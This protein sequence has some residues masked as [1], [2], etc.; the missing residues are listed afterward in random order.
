MIPKT[1][2]RHTRVA[3][4]ACALLANAISASAQTNTLVN[5]GTNGLL[6]YTPIGSGNVVPDYSGVGYKNGE[7]AIPSVPV[8]L[9]LDAVAGDNRAAIQAAINQVAAMPVQANGFR[10][11]ILLRAGYYEVS[12]TLVVKESGI[13]IRG[14]GT[15]ATTGTRIHYTRAVQSDCIHFH[16]GGYWDATENEWALGAGVATDTANAKRVQGSYVPY[17]AKTLTLPSGH[18]FVAGDWVQ[19]KYQYNSVWIDFIKMDLPY[20]W[21]AG[22]VNK[23]ETPEDER[24]ESWQTS[25]CKFSAERKILSVSGNT[26]TLDAPVMDPI[27]S[28]HATVDVVK[29]T[30]QGQ[31]S[32]NCGIENIRFSSYFNPNEKDVNNVQID[33]DHGWKAVSFNNIRNAWARNI[34]SYNFGYSC[35]SAGDSAVFVTVEDCKSFDPKSELG[36]GN[37]YCFDNNGQRNLFQNCTSSGGGR[38]VFVTGSWTAGPNV[39]YNCSAT[40][41]LSDAGPHHRWSTGHLYDNVTTDRDIRIRN[42]GIS[43]TGHGWTGAQIM[44]WNCT[45]TQGLVVQEPPGNHTNWLVGCV[46]PQLSDTPV[47][48]D[49]VAQSPGV[50][51]T[52]IPSLYLAQLNE[53]L[54]GSR[55]AQITYAN[56]GP[57]SFNGSTTFVDAGTAPGSASKLTVAFFAT[58]AKLANMGV[59]DKIPLTGTKGWSLKMRSNGDLWF[60]VGSEGTKTDVIKTAAYAANTRVHIACT[61]ANGTGKIY[62][63]GALTTTVTGIAQTVDITNVNL[64]L[65]IPSLA[66]T[67]NIYQGSLE[68]VKIYDEALSAAEIL[69]LANYVAPVWS[70]AG[71]TT[72]DG[73][74]DFVAGSTSSGSASSLTVAA[75]ITAD[76]L[77]NMGVIDKLPLTGTAG[78][79]LKMRSNGDLWMR[80]GSEASG[81]RT[82]VIATAV[83]TPFTRVHVACTYTA[84]TARI[85]VNGAQVATTSGITQTVNNTATTLR[86]GVPSVAATTN[87]Y[88]GVL[89]DVKIFNTALTPAQI[90]ALQ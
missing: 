80:I 34:H 82:D 84:G 5:Y 61:Y 36:G 12:D 10:G 15:G 29:I 81:S 37:R 3:L 85:Y 8:V 9:T 42:R 20:L 31:R 65:G 7:V 47:E 55:P 78:W 27:D 28:L 39:F 53:R 67:N 40:G 45:A 76:K 83:Y 87:V 23:P 86:L 38:H 21:D 33:K 35:V 59:I 11:A 22:A 14:E 68:Q 46:G 75:Y 18:G 50:K 66:A 57:T 56:N 52:S 30:G 71:P 64:R 4:L 88:S 48:P 43:G 49:V 69:K 79:G 63:N 6:S 19:L 1:G 2:S 13:V 74:D 41:V 70:H 77:A 72:F 25:D 60:R 26:I 89:E 54:G 44:L 90:Q 51:I 17:G 62:I 73:I 32:E 24:D 16:G 58:P